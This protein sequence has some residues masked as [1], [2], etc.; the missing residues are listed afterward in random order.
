MGRPKKITG[1]EVRAL[2]NQTVVKN[3]ELITKTNFNLSAQAQKVILFLISQIK[4]ED[5]DFKEYEFSIPEFCRACG[6]DAD[7]GKHYDAV[8]DAL[9]ELRKAEIHYHGSEWI[10]LQDG[11][12]ALLSWIENPVVNRK[13][14]KIWLR[15]DKNMRPFLL[16]LR[17]HFTKY[18]LIWTLQFNSRYAI[19]LYEFCKSVHYDKSKP[20]DFKMTPKDLQARLGAEIY[21]RWTDV[22]R[23]ALEPAISEVNE[24]SDI[25]VDYEAL[26]KG[27]TVSGIILHME[28]KN[29]WERLKR[30]TEI[31]SQYD[32]DQ[33]S[34]FDE[35][36]Q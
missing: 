6:I 29:Q 11:S 12:E 24:K 7:S 33:V 34:L 14:G 17:D 22:R 10:P 21:T 27:H 18:E 8:K 9:R 36:I 4:P 31:E 23:R 16:H 28:T 30:L 20:Y 19:R 13:N 1:E 3:N 2:Q 35:R 5:D 26:T 15:L 32:L 25:F